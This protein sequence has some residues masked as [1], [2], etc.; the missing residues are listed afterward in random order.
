MNLHKEE[1]R[2]VNQHMKISHLLVPKLIKIKIRFH[3]FPL[4][5][6]L[7]FKLL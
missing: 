3:F 4:D 7:I 2:I 5:K 6:L 1:M